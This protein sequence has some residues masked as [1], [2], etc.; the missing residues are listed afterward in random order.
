MNSHITTFK[1][2]IQPT[3]VMVTVESSK[4]HTQW[5]ISLAMQSCDDFTPGVASL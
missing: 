1:N 4:L 5:T 2:Q 3:Y